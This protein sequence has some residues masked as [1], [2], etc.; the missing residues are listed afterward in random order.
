M[1]QRRS[2]RNTFILH[3]RGR[4]VG[5]GGLDGIITPRVVSDERGFRFLLGA[6]TKLLCNISIAPQPRLSKA[7]CLQLLRPLDGD[8]VSR[9]LR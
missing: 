8:P 7:L 2:K 5:G 9:D 1:M 6:L 4:P 3:S